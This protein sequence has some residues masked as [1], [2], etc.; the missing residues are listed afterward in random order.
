[1]LPMTRWC[2]ILL[3]LLAGSLP[4][5]GC[6]SS[7][8]HQHGSDPDVPEIPPPLRGTNGDVV[9]I[10][11]TSVDCPIANAMAPQ[12][13]RDLDVLESSGARTYLA[14]PRRG[15]TMADLETHAADYGLPTRQLL[16][17]DHVM[18]EALDATVTPQGF[19]IEFG[20]SGDWVTRY[21][22]RVNDLYTSIGDRRDLVTEHSLRDAAMA[23]ID[24]AP[25]SAVPGV[26]VGCMIERIR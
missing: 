22:G 4:G 14:Y 1:M 10:V 15:T 24:G 8:R 7:V 5:I 3:L 17:P 20:P 18:V 2:S 21:A 12:L 16:D 6:G 9:V 25:V 26:P 19:V 23:V 11:F 13:R